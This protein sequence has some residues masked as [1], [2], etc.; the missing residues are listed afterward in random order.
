MA[1]DFIKRFS[2]SFKYYKLHDALTMF[3]K[4]RS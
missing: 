1:L 2:W 3:D 4:I